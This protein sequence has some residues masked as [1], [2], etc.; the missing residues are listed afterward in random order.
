MP[1]LAGEQLG[2]YEILALIGAGGMG[3][4]YRARDPRVNRDVAIKVS[5]AQFTERFEREARAIAA[6][7][8][9]NI[10][11]L[12]DVVISKNAPNYLVM[13]YVEGEAPKGPMPLEEALRVA[14]QIAA[15]LEAAHEKN[16]VHRDL[17]P[18]NIKIK[19]DGTVKVLDFGLAKVTE[20]EAEGGGTNS[21]TLTI[22]MTEAGMILGT[23]AYMSP[24]Q[25]RG[26]KVDKR[27]DI[28]AFGVVLYEMLTGRRLFAGDE[29]GDILAAVIKD[30]PR[31][32]GV[33]AK[34]RPL[35]ERCLEKDPK[36]RLRDIG[37]MNLLLDI[38]VGGGPV[39][40]GGGRA[41]LLPWIVATG[42]AVIA[43]VLAL[44]HFREAPPE[45]HS[46]RFEIAAKADV[47]DV[48][49]SPDGRYL[50]FTASDRLWVRPL[51]SLES[52]ALAGTED[53]R[54]P[55]WSPD[56]AFLGFSAAG[57][58][59]RIAAAG[60]PAQTL[61]DAPAY[62]GGTWNRDGVIVFA[63]NSTGALYRVSAAGGVPAPVTKPAGSDSHRFPEF[64]PDGRHFL[65]VTAALTI[66]EAGGI[67]IGSLD[68]TAERLLPEVSHAAYSPPNGF[69]RTGH[70]LFVR[71]GTLM[72]QAFDPERRRMTGEAFPIAEQVSVN[73]GVPGSAIF[74]VSG[75]GTLVWGT[76]TGKRQ[77]LW[78][79]RTG[80]R[81]SLIGTPGEIA[82]ELLSPD[83]KKVAFV[84]GGFGGTAGAS[85][86]W[87]HDLTRNTTS[88]FTFGPGITLAP[89]WSPD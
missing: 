2:P 80:K 70:L 56:S 38:P 62:R 24:E 79:D 14:S 83:E 20:P 15:A 34:V 73:L 77:L 52:R 19:P 59:K 61:C 3:E 1:L 74:S 63:P 87:V 33:P 16:I 72:A 48:A 22:G 10:C 17:K 44:V 78:R 68:G 9:P 49:L 40:L 30:E 65:F 6:L 26:K 4:V 31:W 21:P 8:H 69:S 66:T 67:Y 12:Y 54:F 36:R 43:A 71:D 58:L 13:E 27:A 55:F 29:V 45:Q 50:A 88:R 11:T 64:L 81:L 76:G 37:D 39:R 89:I 25:A 86:I 75:P 51:D 47:Q 28:W 18:A 41:R 85:D 60:G 57:K 42:F 53:A 46:T 35:L 84:S 5:A 7:N 23:A 32:D 82:F